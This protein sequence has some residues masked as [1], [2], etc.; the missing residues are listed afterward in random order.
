ASTQTTELNTVIN[1]G[2][3]GALWILAVDQGSLGPVLRAAQAKGVP[4]LVNGVPADYGFSGLQ[5][6]ITF[7]SIDYKA[8]GTA[9]GRQ[10]G[11]C[12]NSKL[13]GQA[14]VLFTEAPT[15]TA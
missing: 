4:A 7:D 6:G 9:L 10:L 12:I 1:T 2:V 8:A 14:Q 11:A 15:G 5:P 3:A 13:G